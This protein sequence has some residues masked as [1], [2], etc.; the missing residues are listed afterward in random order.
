MVNKK[1]IPEDLSDHLAK[2]LKK[3]NDSLS[4]KRIQCVYFKAKYDKTPEEI[5]DMVGYN[6]SY[7]RQVQANFWKYG[8]LSFNLKKRGGRNNS[9]FQIE[10]EKELID[11][12]EKESKQG[13]IIEVS[14]I[15]KVLEEKAKKKIAQSTIYRMLDRHNWRKIMPRPYHPKSNQKKT[16]AFKKTTNI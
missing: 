9:I 12:F 4:V 2:L 6:V 8:D 14:K 16:E 13:G 10:E 7:V 5:A 3:T 11:K 1:T 15:H